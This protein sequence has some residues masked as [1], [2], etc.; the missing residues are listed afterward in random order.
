MKIKEITAFPIRISREDDEEGNDRPSV[1]DFGDYFVDESAFTSIYSKHH[2]TTVIKIETDTGIVGWGEA[3]SPVAPRTT[4]VIVED[5]VRP[6]VLGRDPFDIE[7]IWTRNFGAMRERGHPTGFYIDA[8][9]GTDIALWD[10]VG[11]ATGK[12]VH[13]LAGGRYRDKVKLYAGLGGTDPEKVADAA[14][15]HVGLGYKA[16]KLHLLLDVEGVAEIASAVRTRVG[17]DIMLMCDVHMRQSL[18]SA[19]KLGRA[20]EKLDFTWLESPLVPDDIPG[21]VALSEAL[22]MAVAIGEWSRTR[23]EMREA[24]ERRA[25]DIVMH[26]I[27][28]TGIT[29]GHRIGTIADTYNIPVAPHV[30]GGGI[31][32]VA[33]TVE[34]SASCS[35]FM[36]ME[37]GHHANSYKNA[38]TSEEYGP[39]NGY[40]EV[41]DK[42]GL[43]IEIDQSLVEKYL[44]T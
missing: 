2:E 1:I 30:G 22:D 41:S 25:Y 15:E 33:A 5:L 44:V 27:A 4:Q 20:L 14:E 13:K 6:L 12:P 17:P 8:I 42:P 38:I 35:N 37:H 36:I 11:K 21:A 32:S 3:Q 9:G 34:Y 18:T 31:L 39:S 26:D 24:F 28:R 7:A 16:L 10:I 40:F 29:E 23:Y 43:G 19:I